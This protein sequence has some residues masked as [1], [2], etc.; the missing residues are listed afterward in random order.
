M[1]HYDINPIHTVERLSHVDRTVTQNPK[2]QPRKRKKRDESASSDLN[3]AGKED[4]Q[5]QQDKDVDT[6]FL[7]TDETSLDVCI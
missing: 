4:V 5:S 7:V 3:K 6:S 1:D 2:R